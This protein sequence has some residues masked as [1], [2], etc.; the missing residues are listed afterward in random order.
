MSPRLR[1]YCLCPLLECV[2]FRQLAILLRL[3]DLLA[4]KWQESFPRQ[5]IELLPQ[6]AA[7]RQETVEL[8]S[9]ESEMVC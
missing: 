3:T 4:S 1:F 6:W 9:E 5:H 8:S 2:A 7:E